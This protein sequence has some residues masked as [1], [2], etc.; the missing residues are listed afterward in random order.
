MECS[1]SSDIKVCEICGS[2][3]TTPDYRTTPSKPKW[4]KVNGKTACECCYRKDIRMRHG[5]SFRKTLEFAKTL[6]CNNDPLHTTTVTTNGMPVWFKHPEVKDRWL[7]NTCAHSGKYNNWY[8]SEDSNEW[9][10]DRVKRFTVFATTDNTPLGNINKFNY[11]PPTEDMRDIDKLTVTRLRD[12]KER[13]SKVGLNY[14]L[15]VAFISHLLSETEYCMCCSKHMITYKDRQVDR[16]FP[17]LGYIKSNIGII[18]KRCNT[19]KSNGE[20]KEFQQIIDYIERNT[21]EKRA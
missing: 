18:C 2:T 7:C 15:D 3:K 11:K 12:I 8:F 9:K 10:P 5:R 17:S 20:V 16:V 6:S 14:D 19:L 21:S 1:I 4:Y 13:C